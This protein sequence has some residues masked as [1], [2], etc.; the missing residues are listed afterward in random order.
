MN[1]FEALDRLITEHGS[2]TI[3][4]DHLAFIREQAKSLEEEKKELKRRV[5]E[6][7]DL[8]RKLTSELK[9]KAGSEDF[10]EHRG[11]LFKR[12]PSGGYHHAVYCPRCRQAMGS[13]HSQIPYACVQACGTISTIRSYELDSIL[14]ELPA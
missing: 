14:A 4:R 7:E 6:L 11:A 12:K 2:S 8:T 13:I 10:V 9:A 3:L 5:S 1:L